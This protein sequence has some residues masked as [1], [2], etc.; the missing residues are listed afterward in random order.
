MDAAANAAI[1][2]LKGF[3]FQTIVSLG[4]IVWYFTKEVKKD[5]G[6][7]ISALDKDVREMNV[8]LSRLEGTV[9]GVAV[10]K[11]DTEAKA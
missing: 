7:Q 9:Y 6:L 2:F 1:D 11:K 5:L 3:D 4:L 8:R 10:Y